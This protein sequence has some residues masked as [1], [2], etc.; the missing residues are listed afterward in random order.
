M[1]LK[2][3]KF[4]VISPASSINSLENENY[5]ARIL[6]EWI[7]EILKTGIDENIETLDSFQKSQGSFYSNAIASFIDANKRLRDILTAEMK[8]STSKADETSSTSSIFGNPTVIV[9]LLKR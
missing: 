8:M 3:F 4:L 2:L 6:T 9:N 7:N 1:F 5:H